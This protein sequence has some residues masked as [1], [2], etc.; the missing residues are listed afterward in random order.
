MAVLLTLVAGLA[1]AESDKEVEAIRSQRAASNRAIADHDTAAVVA[2]M[3]DDHVITDSTGHLE[4][5]RDGQ[6]ASW[7]QH[8]SAV[9]DVVY[10]RTPVKV[11]VSAA[12]P[13]AFESGAWTGSRST[14]RGLQDKG[15]EYAAVWRK[16]EGTW[17]IHSEIFVALYCRGEGC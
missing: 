15:G 3:S 4:R 16:T 2:F 1:G 10:V 6:T 9:P 12:Y 5:G 7:S 14:A 17:K 11:I 8:F 13:H